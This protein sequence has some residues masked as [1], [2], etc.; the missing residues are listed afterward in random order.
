MLGS[1]SYSSF[2]KLCFLFSFT[3]FTEWYG[4]LRLSEL[5]VIKTV[6]G[7]RE[8]PF[9]FLKTFKLVQKSILVP[10]RF[11]DYVLLFIRNYSICSFFCKLYPSAGAGG[12]GVRP[13][14][15]E[16]EEEIH[17]GGQ[18]ITGNSYK[19]QSITQLLND[20]LKVLH[21]NKWFFSCCSE[22]TVN[23]SVWNFKTD[24]SVSE[25]S[26]QKHF[27]KLRTC[28]E[29][30][31]DPWRMDPKM[32][33]FERFLKKQKN[34]TRTINCSCGWSEVSV[35]LKPAEFLP[36]LDLRRK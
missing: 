9:M 11:W 1:D 10:D 28:K 30:L 35:C 31:S 3:S 13:R 7:T 14:N 25:S 23:G 19:I 26:K 8:E 5:Y 32:F 12:F 6:Q 18:N 33:Y 17:P 29:P 22:R 2:L 4:L 34:K 36:D 24:D 16:C 27:W 15:T 20:F 21:R